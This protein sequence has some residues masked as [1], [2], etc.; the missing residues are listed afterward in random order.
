MLII[1]MLKKKN[2]N[3]FF[4]FYINIVLDWIHDDI[5]SDSNRNVLYNARRSPL[6]LV[7]I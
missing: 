5:Y 6:V 3:V 7:F 1:I 4:V 2:I